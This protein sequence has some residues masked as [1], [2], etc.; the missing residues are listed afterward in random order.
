MKKINNIYFPLY[1]CLFNFMSTS[2]F[3][4]DPGL[5]TTDPGEPPTVVLDLLFIPM[6]ISAIVIFYYVNYKILKTRKQ[7]IN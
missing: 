4:N 1:I 5:P 7:Q 2:M 3:A 6:F